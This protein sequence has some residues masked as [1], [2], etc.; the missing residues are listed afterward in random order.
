[1]IFTRMIAGPIALAVAGAGIV[2]SAMVLGGSPKAAPSPSATASVAPAA[3]QLAA[4][5][6][7]VAALSMSG[8]RAAALIGAL[9]STGPTIA[10][11]SPARGS[12]TTQGAALVA[13]TVQD[14]T[15]ISLLT[16]NGNPTALGT[17]GS[18]SEAVGL[19][20]GLNVIV[21][22]ATNAQ[23]VANKVSLSVIYGQFQPDGQSIPNALAVRLNQGSFD[24]VS[25][26]VASKLSGQMLT[27][28]LLARNP[29]AQ[30]SGF[31]GS[32]NVNCTSA[33]FGNPT[34]ALTPETGDI[35][36]HVEIPSV[37]VGV[38]ENGSGIIPSISGH[39]GCDRAVLDAQ[40]AVS[41]ANGQVTTSVVNDTIN[42]E[43][44]NWGINGLPDFLTGLFTGAV[45]DAI[46]GEVSNMIKSTLPP[47]VNSMI[48]GATGKPITQQILGSTATFDLTPGSISIDANG[49]SATVNADCSLTPVAGYAPLPAPGSLVSGGA[50]PQNGGP[51]PDFFAS[52]NVDL[53]NRAGYAAWKSGVAQIRIDDSPGSAFHMPAGYPLDMGLLLTF[54]PE[55]TGTGAASDPIAITV[56]PLLPPV[57]RALPAPDTLEAGLGELQMKFV[58]TVTNQT[59]LA[60]AVHVRANATLT[61][62]AQNTFDVQMT[63]RPQ[64]DVS[65]VSSAAANMNVIGIDNVMTLFL[66]TIIQIAGNQW[67]GFPL[68]TYPGLTPTGTSIYWDGAN[69]TFVTAAG[70]FHQGGAP[71]PV[72]K[73]A[74]A[75][76]L[77]VLSTVPTLMHPL[78]SAILSQAVASSAVSGAAK[79][80]VGTTKTPLAGGVT[81]APGLLNPTTVAVTQGSQA[82]ATFPT[83]ITAATGYVCLVEDG[84]QAAVAP[85]LQGYVNRGVP[86]A[87]VPLSQVV[88]PG[89]DR[90][91]Q[92][93][94]WLVANCNDGV[95]RYL[96]LVGGPTAIPFRTCQPSAAVTTVVSDLYYGDLKGNWDSNGNGVYGE[97]TDQPLFDAQLY[98]GRI[99]YDDAASV[100]TAVNAIETNRNNRGAWSNRALLVGA[101]TIVAGDDP[102]GADTAKALAFTPE[103]WDTTT[104]FA[105]ESFIK[106]DMVL[107]PDTIVNQLNANPA[108]LVLTFSHG[109]TQGLMSH[110]TSTTW[111]DVLTI[112]QL[113]QLPK[114]TP[115]VEIAIAC[116]TADPSGGPCIGSE[117]L[118]NGLAGWVGCTV[119]TD[120]RSGA[121]G[122][123][124]ATV[125]LSQEVAGGKP[126]G[127]ALA[128]TVRDFVATGL[129][130]TFG[131]DDATADLYQQG[132]SWI[133][134]GDPGLSLGPNAK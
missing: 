133:C 105:P 114:S 38:Q 16:I 65:L 111:A 128:D 26:V 81:L 96:L 87:E 113:A 30:W 28:A 76:I 109:S 73:P 106:G 2:G 1:M 69:E 85:L 129:I 108:G 18:F 92:I 84:L 101:T 124:L 134:Y 53:L 91:E 82:S 55:L 79:T 99:P 27:N 89:R 29:L 110:P 103:G 57:F 72:G 24:A 44:F 34:V 78:S 98:V 45:R 50:V 19:T 46:Q 32:A 3:T 122:W 40:I 56:T 22:E 62:N 77:H 115:P 117:A 66:P 31:I 48:A 4:S 112:P 88:A 54:L 121:G 64:V 70:N 107:D 95:K 58:D 131:N 20:P 25:Q 42:L 33:S 116:N 130:G 7:S 43:N 119:V 100:T 8:A 59:V 104:A 17:G 12:F 86:V 75:P 37:S 80:V 13:G 23:G 125:Q 47:E 14:A 120:P 74:P 90:A 93:K 49:L 60:L 41:V 52:A 15:A 5:V 35:R 39:A 126:L 36:V 63:E 94:N 71:L 118:E 102:I 132:M 11:T 97:I 9:A 67:S 123:L 68:P 61:L 21:V 83:Q 10:L 6:P 127:V 51:G